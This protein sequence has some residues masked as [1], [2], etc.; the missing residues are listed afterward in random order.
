MRLETIRYSGEL[1][2]SIIND[3]LEMNKLMTT[4]VEFESAPFSLREL[5]DSVL[6]LVHLAAS[7]S[8]L[9][10]SSYVPP[11]LS[12]ILSGDSRRIRQVRVLYCV[13]LFAT[14]P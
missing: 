14:P 7:D 9:T 4:R 6:D 5:L 3:L 2:L 11:D 13:T 1:L 8:Q 12:D 10:I